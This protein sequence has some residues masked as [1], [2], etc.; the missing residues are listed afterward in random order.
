MPDLRFA[1]LGT[2]FWSLFQ[3]PAWAEAGGGKPVAVYNRTLSKAQQVATRFGISGVY[4]DPEELL[5]AES[6]RLDFIDIITAVETHAPLVKLAAKYH[7]PVI[8]Q[9]PMSTDLAS[10]ESMVSVCR[11]AGFPF[12]FTRTGAGKHRSARFRP[13]WPREPLACHSAGASI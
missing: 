6:D 11:E 1:V 12:I 7:L 3:I 9:K 4:G 2:G 8:C 10:A 5:R 13:C